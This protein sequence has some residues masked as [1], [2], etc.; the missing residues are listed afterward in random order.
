MDG[1]RTRIGLAARPTRI[2][3]TELGNGRGETR[4]AGIETRLMVYIVSVGLLV[5]ASLAAIANQ[6]GKLVDVHELPPFVCDRVEVVPALTTDRAVGDAGR[7]KAA[8]GKP[9]SR[10]GSR[11]SI[12][13]RVPGA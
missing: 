4:G 13:A 1:G 2:A 10:P 7:S 8:P 9:D 11:D 3:A 12:C 6:S 5:A